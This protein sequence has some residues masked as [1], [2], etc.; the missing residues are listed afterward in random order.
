MLELIAD[1]QSQGQTDPASI[2]RRINDTNVRLVPGARYAGITVLESSRAITTMASTAPNFHAEVPGV[3]DEESI[4]I[5]LLAATHTVVAWNLVSGD[6]NSALPWPVETSS[7]EPRALLMER[8]GIDAAA[9]FELLK[10]LS[11]EF[12]T[13][14][15]EI[16]EKVV[17]SAHRPNG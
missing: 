4:E 10:R 15:V 12:N 2:L 3:S 17:T 14:L 8:F 11:Q 9:A 6:R 1:M 7:R 16:A 13:K 5:G